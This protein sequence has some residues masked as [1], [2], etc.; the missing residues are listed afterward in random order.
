MD[1][2]WQPRVRRVPPLVMPVPVDP[3]G[4]AG[5]T[6]GEA[7]G[8]HWRRTGSNL[9]VPADVDVNF[10]EQRALEAF[11]VSRG[12]GAV[13]GWAALRLWGAAFFDGLGPDGETRLA[14]S[15]V[16]GGARFRPTPALHP[17]RE[18]LDPSSVVARRGVGCVGPERALLHEICRRGDLREAVVAIDMA[19]AGQVTSVRRLERYLRTRSGERGVALARRASTLADEHAA[20]PQEVRF[21]LV[22]QLDAGWEPPLVNRVL[23]DLQGRLLGRPDLFDPDRGVVGEFAGADHRH[24]ER[25][26]RDV[27][28][29]DRFRRAGLEYVEVVGA[30]LHDRDRVVGRMEAAAR[31][32]GRTTRGWRMGPEP[33]PLD[34]V[35]DHRDA[36]IALAE[37]E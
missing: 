14:V 12:R 4:R 36:M 28:R 1:D 34:D 29:E 20:S 19:A 10:P 7:A 11:A 8:P 6:R 27:E 37:R 24:R 25:H 16:Q 21:R 31:R 5:P 17:C 18:S 22:W 33:E 2:H 9:Y 30:D 26:R 35:L 23:L 32:A 13:T 15:V 3:T